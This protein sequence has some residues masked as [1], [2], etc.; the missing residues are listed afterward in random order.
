[1]NNLFITLVT[2]KLVLFFTVFFSLGLQAKSSGQTVTLHVKSRPIKTVLDDLTKQTKYRFI[3]EH[4]L[5]KEAWRVTLEAKDLSLEEAMEQITE[6]LPLAYSMH[7]GVVLIKK[8]APE[9]ATGAAPMIAVQQYAEGW[10]V[11]E[12]GD[13]LAGVSIKVEGTGREAATD[14]DGAFR[15]QATVG[16]RLT[17]SYLGYQTVQRTVTANQMRIVMEP[18]VGEDLDE[19]VVV[20]VGYGAVKRSDL[21]GSIASVSADKLTQVNAVSTVA[22]GLQGHAA[23]VQVTQ[24]SGQPGEFM[25][26]KI[27]GTNSLGASNEP[28][29]VVDGMPLD[30]LT[31]QLNPNDVESVSVLKDASS[32]AIYGSRGANGVIMITTK[33]GRTGEPTIAY[34]GYAGAQNL[35][36]KIDLINASE[37]AQLQN[38]VAAN[39]GE[40]LPWTP[41]EIDALGK[42]T[43]WQDLVYRTAMV[44]SHDVSLSGGSDK[45]KYYS[46]FGYFN[47][48]GII[49]NSGFDRYSFR[50]NLD[51]KLSERLQ[52]NSSFSVQHSVYERAQYQSAD[53]SGG[54]PFTTMVMPPTDGV[55]NENG[56][57]TRVTGVPWGETNPVG[58]SRNW[59]NPSH[60][61]RLLG[62]VQL[63]YQLTAGLKVNVSAGLD[64]SNNKSDTYYPGNITLGQGTDADGQPVFGRA[65]RTYGSSFSF[66]NENTLEYNN[67]FGDHSLNVLAGMTYQDSRSDGLNSGTALGFLSDIYE[68][69]NIQSAATKALPSSSFSDNKLISYLG[70]ANYH[71]ANKYY[72]TLTARYDGSSRFGANNKFAFFPSGALAWAVS[73][74]DFLK[75]N[76]TVSNLKLRASYGLSGNQAIASYQTLAN[77][78]SVDVAFNRFYDDLYG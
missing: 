37:F 70:R 43:D 38:E 45:T 62:N 76:P 2:M 69:Y 20:V 41:Q 50:V 7:D 61:L 19:V 3:Y 28:L 64:Q 30:A 57:Y 48:D 24:A 1:M 8:A 55:Y 51:Q 75:D 10:V 60:S 42:G 18:A 65:A 23:G 77:L 56:T 34:S 39:D 44:Q 9:K 46:S 15:V 29:Y 26:I 33:K 78:A 17:F 36:K 73:E 13:P 63:S 66:L 74:E 59:H 14:D 54:I 11:D 72:V 71:Y 68:T 6:G 40:S 47:Q 31:S 16:S 21:T 53:G 27:R 49:R 58:L 5:L 12:R 25:R 4:G 67:Q 35:R 32:T 22:Q 52:F